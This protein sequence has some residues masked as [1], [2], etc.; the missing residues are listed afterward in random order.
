MYLYVFLLIYFS[1]TALLIQIPRDTSINSSMLLQVTACSTKLSVFTSVDCGLW[2]VDEFM[3][4]S[5]IYRS[6]ILFLLGRIGT[7]CQLVNLCILKTHLKMTNFFQILV[8][9][10]RFCNVSVTLYEASQPKVLCAIYFTSM[11]IWSFISFSFR[12][13]VVLLN[14]F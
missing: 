6:K 11:S 1:S 13:Q 12:Q 7:S 14:S 3:A 4:L 10:C 8:G 2:I 9:Y 5:P